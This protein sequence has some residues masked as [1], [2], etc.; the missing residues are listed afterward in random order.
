M[1]AHAILEEFTEK[2]FWQPTTAISL[3]CRFIDR[4]CGADALR[5][6]LEGV[7]DASHDDL[8]NVVKYEPADRPQGSG[9]VVAGGIFGQH[10]AYDRAGELA[11]AYAEAS[12][13]P[14]ML[15]RIGWMHSVF[16][17]HDPDC[18]DVNEGELVASFRT[19]PVEWAGAK[20]KQ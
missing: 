8:F 14:M 3:L 6:F 15:Y 1:S 5:E 13:H 9:E 20:A 19:E 4:E 10:R 7:S 17:M 12:P 11:R 16:R 2:N 18:D